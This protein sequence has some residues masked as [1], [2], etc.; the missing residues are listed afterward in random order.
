MDEF[1][2]PI[3]RG[4]TIPYDLIRA[5]ET[6]IDLDVKVEEN[7]GKHDIT[8]I[9]E[10]YMCDV[11]DIPIQDA[12]TA[13]LSR[14][15][16]YAL[17]RILD[18]SIAA[19]DTRKGYQKYNG[20]ERMTNQVWLKWAIKDFMDV[21]PLK[22]SLT[23]AEGKVRYDL[24]NCSVRMDA[25]K[26]EAVYYGWAAQ[27]VID[28]GCNH[29]RSELLQHVIRCELLNCAQ[30]S[31]Y[32]LKPTQK[33]EPVAEKT[34]LSER[35]LPGS[36]HLTS[37]RRGEVFR[38]G[39]EQY[40]RM[41][42]GW[43]R[44][45][46]KGHTPEKIQDEM[47]ELMKIRD[48]WKVARDRRE[49]KSLELCKLL[50]SVGR[51][52]YDKYEEPKDEEAMSL[53]FQWNLDEIFKTDNREHINI[54]VEKSGRTNDERFFALIM[55]AATDTN[56]GR[57]WWSNM[58]PCLRGALI[59]GETQ[60]GDVYKMLRVR[61][62][63]S[64]RNEYSTQADVARQNDNYTF[65]RVNLF[66]L[67]S[68]PATPVIHWEYDLD[69]PRK[70]NY[71]D[72]HACDEFPDD[73]DLVCSFDETKYSE[74]IQRILDGGWDHKN[75]KYYKILK[76]AGNVLTIDFEKDAR[77][78][79]H[80][81]MVMPSYFN[82]RIAAPMFRCILRIC[83]TT[84]SVRQNADPAVSRTIRPL[85]AKAADL[86]DFTLGS[87]Y[88]TRFGVMGRTL[89]MSQKQS[90]MYKMIQEAEDYSELMKSRG[91]I[92][93]FKNPCP[94]T[95]ACQYTLQKTSVLILSRAQRYFRE[96]HGGDQEEYMSPT[97]NFEWSDMTS[98]IYDVA[99]MVVLVF[100]V[101]FERRRVVRGV[102]ESR[103]ILHQLRI[104]KGLNR[105]DYVKIHFPHLYQWWKAS[106]STYGE[107]QKLNLLPLL[108]LVGDNFI[109]E[110][111]QWAYP[112]VLISHK[113]RF[114]PVELG[115][116][117]NRFGLTSLI[118][119]LTF[120]VGKAKYD[121][122]LDQA[123]Q[124][125]FS[126]LKDYYAE[127]TITDG[128]VNTHSTMTKDPIY[129]VYLSTICGGLLDSL[130]YLMPITHPIKSI[131]AIVI[132][133][134][135][136][137]ASDCVRRVTRK[138]RYIQHHIRGSVVI[139][140][141][142]D[143]SINTYSEGIAKATLCDKSVLKYSYKVVLIKVEGHVFGHDEMLTKLLNV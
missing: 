7:E 22:V 71:L 87:Y 19:Y 63:W 117:Y 109:Y 62:D 115:A 53:R 106:E 136:G 56:R 43:Y 32:M 8:K 98:N 10:S 33:L 101:L 134:G 35:L 141:L 116:Y 23:D 48:R 92:E 66:D 78:N 4:R 18:V 124:K 81:E 24:F 111:R 61:F 58:F 128:G 138:L 70:T 49:I 123:E 105:L 55:I 39:T 85:K 54:A 59:V 11:P 88:D 137:S 126:A 28:K 95:T 25:K 46:V 77:L 100:D 41:V 120:H 68:E 52:M 125:V 14:N 107:A 90:E 42:Q 94:I 57:I 65:T 122:N 76:D 79:E 132:N 29:A 121:Q 38:M 26:A 20:I 103:F 80:S 1:A 9:P 3:V 36:S 64:V 129:Q 99:Q 131:V 114:I 86:L 34:S 142:S 139:S 104:R 30:E 45:K 118:S 97:L 102:D 140:I 16:G 15:D 133:D 108:F 60:F 130:V 31:A 110:H 40:N 2:V 27:E 127:S 51:K 96:F 72:G 50:S 135:K 74:M 75:F 119:H 113:L 6:I 91:V 82:K 67:I 44:V 69:A 143:G 12:T 13:T 112:A 89:V 83:E 37:M 17:P 21:Q 73:Y 47:N 5:Y 84:I 93:K